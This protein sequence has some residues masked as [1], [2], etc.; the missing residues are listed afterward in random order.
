MLENPPM[1]CR[2]E[3]FGGFKLSNCEGLAR[4]VGAPYHNKYSDLSPSR[5]TQFIRCYRILFPQI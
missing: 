2:I 3:F 1:A 5:L 4:D